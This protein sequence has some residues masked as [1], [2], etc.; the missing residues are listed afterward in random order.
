VSTELIVLVRF[1]K[2]VVTI[3]VKFV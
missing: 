3:A 2:Y 1:I